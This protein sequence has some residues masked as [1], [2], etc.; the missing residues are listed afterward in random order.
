[1]IST[2]LSLLAGILLTALTLIPAVADAAQQRHYASLAGPPAAKPAAGSLGAA[3]KAWRDS[4]LTRAGVRSRAVAAPAV[5][6]AVAPA[7]PCADTTTMPD[8]TNVERIRA[9]V[10]CLVNEQRSANG[11]VPLTD[12]IQLRA[13]AQAH[14]DDM[15]GSAYFA[16][17]TPDGTDFDA[18]IFAAG[19]ADAA[20]PMTWDI[21]AENIA[22]GADVIATPA[23]TVENWMASPAHRSNIL[24]ARLRESGIGVSLG[25]PDAVIT[26]PAATYTQDFGTR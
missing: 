22:W 23:R 12:N 10:L 9:S 14:S 18:R 7:E 19:Y 6:P 3:M 15:V 11:L 24:D 5:V 1:M 4:R 25:A 26:G 13:A 20:H 16:H 2:R 21:L 8:A 17:V